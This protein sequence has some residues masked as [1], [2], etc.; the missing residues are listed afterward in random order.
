M[1]FLN[2]ITDARRISSGVVERSQSV[3]NNEE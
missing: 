2:V 3:N 1:K